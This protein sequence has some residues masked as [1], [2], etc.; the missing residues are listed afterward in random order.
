[1][2]HEPDEALL[3]PAQV[4]ALF[5]V[6]P[7]TVSSWGDAGK[8][9]VIRTL[10]GHRR[11]KAAEVLG[12]PTRSASHPTARTR[13]VRATDR[14]AGESGFCRFVQVRKLRVVPVAVDAEGW[15]PAELLGVRHRRTG[16]TC[17]PPLRGTTHTGADRRSRPTDGA[18]LR[19]AGFAQRARVDDAF[20]ARGRR[21]A[22]GRA[23]PRVAR[24]R[25]R[26]CELAWSSM[27]MGA[28]PV[29]MRAS[30]FDGSVACSARVRL[31]PQV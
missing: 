17:S 23:S 7:R 28:C 11:F 31:M 13:P 24:R 26:M 5:D 30:T 6:D 29:D 18:R 14:A 8:L 10:G 4:A 27:S 19:A 12:S 2:E 3:K 9:T 20:T 16:D 21:T 22:P 1:M 15:S 25:S